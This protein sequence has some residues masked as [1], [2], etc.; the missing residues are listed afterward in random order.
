M[1]QTK[2]EWCDSTLNLQ[3]GCDGC[4]LWNPGA[5][6][7][8]CYA[9]LMTEHRAGPPRF[10]E[11]FDKPALFPHHLDEGAVTP[12]DL[13]LLQQ[14]PGRSALFPSWKLC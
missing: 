8:R 7:R 3:M 6:V 5:G 13:R 14:A 12:L 9:G 4:E 2:I 11:A 1:Q 10:P